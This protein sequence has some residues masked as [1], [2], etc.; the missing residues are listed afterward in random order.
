MNTH[1]SCMCTRKLNYFNNLILE[2]DFSIFTCG[3]ASLGDVSR[4]SSRVNA[5][6]TQIL[7]LIGL[8]R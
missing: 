4:L 7:V 6:T 3:E 2:P 1:T 5:R 8:T